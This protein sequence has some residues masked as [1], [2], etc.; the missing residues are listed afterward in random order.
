MGQAFVKLSGGGNDFLALVEPASVPRREEIA[1]WCSRG[2][3]LGADGLFVL[4]RS[5]AGARM[6]YFNADGR[7]AALCLNGTRCAARLAFAEGWAEREVTIE[8]GAGRVAA[9]LSAPTTVVLALPAPSSPAPAVAEVEGILH[10]GWS[11]EVGVP[12]FVLI[13]PARLD[14]APVASLGRAL[15]AH[16]T[17]A[18]R[19]TNV[20]FVGFADPGRLEIR[21]WERGVERETLAC[22][23][24]ALA[25]AATG[26]ALGRSRLPVTVETRGG[27]LLEVGEGAPGSWTLGGDAR[28]VARGELL[29]EAATL[30]V[31]PP[32]SATVPEAG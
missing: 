4:E 24:G 13:W 31:P 17:F 2:L 3:S 7:E 12:H 20:D 28:V 1:A 8:T 5:A 16:P 30:P 25:A 19:G 15:R 22:G 26:L 21:T 18:P 32:G 27:F 23:T 9:R 6:T 29:P 14:E 10:P 11:V